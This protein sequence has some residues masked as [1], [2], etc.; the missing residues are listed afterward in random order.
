MSSWNQEPPVIFLLGPTASGKSELAV[1]VAQTLNAEIISVDSAMVY[2]GMDIGTAKPAISTRSRVPHSLIDIRE[3]WQ[4]YSAAEFCNDA[5][6]EIKRLRAAGRP[7]ILTGGTALYFRALEFGL[8]DL[9]G[10][11]PAIRAEIQSEAARLGWPALHA[12]LAELDE[13]RARQIHPNDQQRIERALEIVRVT[14]RPPSSLRAS[15]RSTE[16]GSILGNRHCKIVIAPD[17]RAALHERINQRLMQMMANNFLQEV[18]RL[19]ENPK[20][21]ENN[22]AARAVGYRQLW[23]VVADNLS[24]TEGVE[25]AK[26]ATRQLAKRQ[27]T[28]LRAQKDAIWLHSGCA[29]NRKRVIESIDRFS[30]R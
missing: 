27:L 17:S 6:A 28:W 2:R 15:T 30:F 9:P 23:P 7:M 3:P 4:D 11:D 5:Q 20:I 21:S 10:R 13:L 12:Q 16:S 26:T 25:R 14:G 19:V 8:S 18:E 29:G 24:I 1:Q 22:A